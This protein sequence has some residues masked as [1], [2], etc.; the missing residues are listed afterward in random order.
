MI[1]GFQFDIAA[2][3]EPLAIDHTR[4]GT[5][6]DPGRSLLFWHLPVF[7]RL[8]P[9]EAWDA[10]VVLAA[11]AAVIAEGAAHSSSGSDG[12]KR[13]STAI[14]QPG[15]AGSASAISPRRKMVGVVGSLAR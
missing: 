12:T 10:V 2:H 8:V 6:V 7:H 9:T 15:T 5:E 4:V 14:R 1:G 3:K 11:G 13:S